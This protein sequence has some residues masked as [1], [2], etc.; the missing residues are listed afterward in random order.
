[1]FLRLALFESLARLALRVSRAQQLRE[2]AY[3][4]AN[5]LAASMRRGTDEFGKMLAQMETEP[6][7]LQ[8]C[9]VT[10]LAERLQDQ[11]NALGPV[12]HW[13]EERGKMALTELLRTEHSEEAAERIST[14]NAFISLRG[15]AR[16]DFEKIFEAVSLVDAALRHG[17]APVYA[18]SDFAT[19]DQCRRVVE[20]VAMESGV[21]E[22]AVAQKAVALAGLL[23]TAQTTHA[24]YYLLAE[25]VAELEQSLGARVPLRIR[26]IR[27]LRQRAT[28]AYLLAV[29]GITFS[30]LALALT[31]AW[32]ASVHQK[33][34]LLVLGALALFPLGELSIQIV[35]ALVISLLPPDPL[36]NSNSAWHPPGASDARSRPD[37]ADEHRSR[38]PR[39]REARSAVSREPRRQSLLQLVFGFHGFS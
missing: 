13:I 25:G 4:W 12:T 15:V 23:G 10:S 17:P 31:L 37:D 39:N 32:E 29:A 21:A 11:E 38:A 1:M 8:A 14:A 22:L 16:L 19:R 36:P 18:Q 20:R 35:N 27:I 34:L 3:L 28:P 9:F 24:L 30:F 6:F 26:V 5:R 7:A 2:V 33:A